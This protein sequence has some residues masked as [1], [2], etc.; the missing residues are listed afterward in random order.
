M[1]SYPSLIVRFIEH[2]FPDVLGDDWSP[3]FTHKYA[4]AIRG[5]V[6]LI[7]HLPPAV[8]NLGA[9]NYQEWTLA[10]GMIREALEYWHSDPEWRFVKQRWL[11]DHPVRT[12]WR[13]LQTLPDQVPVDVKTRLRFVRNKQFR[14]S[15]LR[16]LDSAAAAIAAGEWKTATLLSGASVEAMLLDALSRRAKDKPAKEA[17]QHLRFEALIDR[18]GGARVVRPE[19]VKTLG[20]VRGFRNLI[21]PGKALRLKAECSQATAYAAYGG[22]LLVERDL[23]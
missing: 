23:G 19:T 10:L 16:D 8:V 22:V 13:L 12:V 15:I 4:P 17:L 9:E 11:P 21:H 6:D 2:C 18:A 3:D 14:E 20:V 7:D 1:R 5:V